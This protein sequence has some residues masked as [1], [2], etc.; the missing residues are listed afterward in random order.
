LKELEELTALEIEMNE[1]S[2][3]TERR[4]KNVQRALRLSERI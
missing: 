1:V 3:D 2:K 4:L